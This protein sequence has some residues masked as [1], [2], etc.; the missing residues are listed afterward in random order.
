MFPIPAMCTAPNTR[1]LPLLIDQFTSA[2]RFVISSANTRTGR[3]DFTVADSHNQHFKFPFVT[4]L[5][6]LSI[7]PVALIVRI[8]AV[9]VA[10]IPRDA[11]PFFRPDMLSDS[12]Y[13]HHQFSLFNLW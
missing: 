13:F 9:E 2:W 5:V 4:L 11:T 7:F 1:L 8:W 3:S 10:V 6:P 12:G